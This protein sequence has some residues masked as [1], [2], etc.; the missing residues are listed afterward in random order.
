MSYQEFRRILLRWGYCFCFFACSKACLLADDDSGQRHRAYDNRL[1]PIINPK[2]LLA[3]HP[4][5]VEPIREAGRFEGPVLI[6]DEEADLEV[7]AW[8]FSYNARG[9]IEMPN[10]LRAEHTAVIVV[11]PWGIDDGRGWRTPEPAGVAFA[12]T[13]EKN[14][15]CREHMKQVVDPFLKSLRGKVG[16]VAF[17]LPGSEDP[18]RKKIYRSIR[19]APTEEE[20]QQGL[21]TASPGARPGLSNSPRWDRGKGERTDIGRS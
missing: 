12:C 3:D 10:R 4:E 13:P 5:F 18:I 11:H 19:A 14:R 15:I 9:I 8:R 6:D 7:R 20:R 2:P 1:T 21:A 16:L 17:S